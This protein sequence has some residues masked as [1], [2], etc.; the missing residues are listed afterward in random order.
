MTTDGPAIDPT[1]T[2]V[3]SQYKHSRPLTSCFWEPKGRYVFFGAEDHLVHRLDV[4]SQTVTALARHDSWVR[5]F[6]ASADGEILF[7]GGYDGRLIAWPTASAQ[8]EP[9]RVS[10]AHAGWIRAL[11]VSP[12]GKLLASCGNDR[13]IKIWD[14]AQGT[15]VR[16]CSGHASHVYNVVFAPDSAS[17]Y[18]C[19]LHG[20]VK[21]WDMNSGAGRDVLTVKALHE[22]DTT[23]RADIGG[24]RS[25]AMNPAGTQLALGGITNVSNAFAGVGDVALALVQPAAGKL[26]LLLGAKE[27]TQGAVW[28][29]AHHP[30]GFWV[31]VSGGGGGFL[32]FWKGDAPHEFFKL[33]LPSDGRGMSL[34]PDHKRV[35]VAHSDGH[36]RIYAMHA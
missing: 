5:A 2:R 17:L 13:L 32:L 14:V 25:I 6:A 7:T 3:V 12:D 4:A 29:V 11:S 20:V 34:S 16:T 26:D 24:A 18:S 15:L 23:F 28:G 19:D 35:A 8:P 9:V 22:Y 10:D 31:G 30:S 1:K 33:K 36:L 27:K 21:A